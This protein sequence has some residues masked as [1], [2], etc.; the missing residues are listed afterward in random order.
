MTTPTAPESPRLR[1]GLW[2]ED[3]RL[4]MLIE[5]EARTITEADIVNF[6][7]VSGD[8]LPLHT[9]EEYAK[10]TPFR[11]RIAHGMLIQSVATGL[12]ARTGVFEGTIAALTGMTIRWLQPV[13][14]GDTIR[15][16][17]EVSEL[18]PKPSRRRGR[19]LLLCRIMN[20]SDK[21]VAEGDWDTLMLRD[22]ARAGDRATDKGGP[23]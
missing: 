21:L 4:G 15:L 16:V 2:F 20:Q 12:C 8:F 10:K 3:F 11:R 18:D 22:L 14:P 1:H 13:Y 6:A 19:V 23:A 9:N 17:L 5:S 7:G